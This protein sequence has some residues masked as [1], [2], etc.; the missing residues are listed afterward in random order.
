MAYDDILAA[1]KPLR[2]YLSIDVRIHVSRTTISLPIA[3][4]DEYVKGTKV[5]SVYPMVNG[6]FRAIKEKVVPA[7]PVDGIQVYLRRP[8]LLALVQKEVESAQGPISVNGEHY[9]NLLL[10]VSPVNGLT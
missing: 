9:F 8:N 10:P 5:P 1:L 2:P 3:S 7:S 4:T 6:P